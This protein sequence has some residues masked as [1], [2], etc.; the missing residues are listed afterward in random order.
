MSGD[1][2]EAS[3]RLVA[4]SFSAVGHELAGPLQT[5]LNALFLL[6]R[7][8]AQAPPEF[9]TSLRTLEAA[10][11]TLRTRLDRVLRLPQAFFVTRQDTS[12]DE[13]IDLALQPLGADA[14]RVVLEV[15]RGRRLSI[16]PR[17][18]ALAVSELLA[19]ALEAGPPGAP[20][21]LAAGVEGHAFVARVGNG[22]PGFP[23]QA[24]DPFFTRHARTLGLG[25]PVAKAVA[26][27]HGGHLQLD[28]AAGTSVA[29]LTLPGDPA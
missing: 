16:D 28:D 18:A 22:G 6:E 25:L 17:G 8:T 10:M 4:K 27:A 15:A 11:D 29:T 5:A 1:E 21:S 3:L 7:K 19:N 23:V 14:K 26:L 13:V 12:V 9:T 2:S 20:V 24:I